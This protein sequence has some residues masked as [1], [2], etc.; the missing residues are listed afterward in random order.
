MFA[1]L[2]ALSLQPAL[3]TAMWNE[4]AA[5]K[6]ALAVLKIGGKSDDA[7]EELDA[8]DVELRKIPSR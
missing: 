6:D 3:V 5:L 7:R 2:H 1:M 8:L 4:R